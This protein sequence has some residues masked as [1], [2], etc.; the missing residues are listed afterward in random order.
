MTTLHHNAL[1]ETTP[2]AI[3]PEKHGNSEE[4][5]YV[6]VTLS[7]TWMRVFPQTG[8]DVRFLQMTEMH[9]DRFAPASGTGVLLHPRCLGMEVER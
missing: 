4:T 8:A 7:G 9:C 2:R 6:A 5:N 3:Q 1:T